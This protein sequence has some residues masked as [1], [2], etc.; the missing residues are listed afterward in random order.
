MGPN[1]GR[2]LLAAAQQHPQPPWTLPGRLQRQPELVEALALRH[3]DAVQAQRGA[4]QGLPELLQEGSGICGRE[5]LDVQPPGAQLEGEGL[6]RPFEHFVHP[7][8]VGDQ[9]KGQPI[10][11][12][13]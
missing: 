12:H 3:L 13:A 2:E 1:E 11:P 8:P 7:A 5:E 6:A 9:G 10:A 4:T